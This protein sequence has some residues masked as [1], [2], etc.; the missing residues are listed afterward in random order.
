M[1]NLAVVS[2]HVSNGKAYA[3]AEIFMFFLVHALFDISP[4]L[5]IYN[6]Y[7]RSMF[8]SQI[9]CYLREL[10]HVILTFGE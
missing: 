9:A 5:N 3:A 4:C 1:A 2:R 6:L 7:P 8:L 10:V